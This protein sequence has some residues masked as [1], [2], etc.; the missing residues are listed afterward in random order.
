MSNIYQF[1]EGFVWGSATAAYQ[2]EG[3]PLADGAGPSIWQRFAHTPGRML[4]D[5]T[6][7]VACD[8]YNRWREDIA[9]MKELGMQAYRFSISW[10]RVLPEGRGRV[11]QKGLD[12]YERLVDTLLE[13][14][15]EPVATLFHWDLPAALDDQGGWLNR[16][17]AGW[18]AD[19]GRVMFERL[20]G[21]IKRWATL[22]EPWV[23]T[24]GGYLHGALAPGHRNRFEA[25]IASHNLMRAHGAA[26]KAYRE[27]GKHEIGLVVN[28]E[29]KYPASDSP[30]DL[31]AT[32]RAEAYMNRQYLDP[33]F[34]GTYPEELRE[35]FGEA[36]P[37][38]SQEDMDL[39][40]QPLDFIGVNY[41]TRNVSRHDESN[42]P[43]K[44][45]P[46]RQKQ[47][48]YTETG[49]EVFPQGLTDTLVWVKE[50]YGNPKVFI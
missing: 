4:N 18:F 47:H 31:A 20:D 13:N 41:Y 15:I 50:R 49:W 22:N 21:R 29:P 48:T 40:R 42:W 6:G 43:L 36:W 23:V 37:E 5:D 30:E 10:S 3:S 14:G 9:I 17:I 7:D 19:Y 27:T 26:V 12:F 11:N 39:I 33:A 32:R 8:H 16:D 35:I 25:P 24:D 2:I 28:I 44:V 46:V 38:W 1:P 45:A 34:F